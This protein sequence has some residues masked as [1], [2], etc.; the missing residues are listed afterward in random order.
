MLESWDLRPDVVAG[1]S[2]GA[3]I[4]GLYASGKTP[5]EM[6][7]FLLE[8]FEIRKHLDKWVFQLQGG[9]IIKFIQAEDALYSLMRTNAIDSG[10]RALESLRKLTDDK[11]F[12]QTR[13][14]FACNA[15]DLLTGREVVLDEGNV[16]EAIRAS[17]SLPGIFEPVRW[18]DML[19][20]DGG[21]LNNAPVWIAKKMGAKK[22]LCIKVGK[23]EPVREEDLGNG[24]SIFWRSHAITSHALHSG[25]KKE[26]KVLEVCAYDGNKVLD[27]ER[28]KEL[29]ELGENEILKNKE[30][31]LRRFDKRKLFRL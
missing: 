26:R 19:L 3:I 20:V 10:K 25:M 29:I 13:I 17:M 31:I 21:I 12:H 5:A 22:I 2:M 16:A 18:K 14:P 28:K 9:R 7:S 1:T 23:F 6:E 4:G 11:E 24:I 30:E 15:V 8:E 27:F